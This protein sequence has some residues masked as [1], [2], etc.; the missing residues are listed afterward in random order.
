[1]AITGRADATDA[2]KHA[3]VPRCAP[4]S[5]IPPSGMLPVWKILAIMLCSRGSCVSTHHGLVVES[6]LFT[7]KSTR[8]SVARQESC[9]EFVA[10]KLSRKSLAGSA[11]G[12]GR[13]EPLITPTARRGSQG[14]GGA[15]P[16][17]RTAHAREDT[18]GR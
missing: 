11:V 12:G 17:G 15:A 6:D 13:I 7:L 3:S 18:V 9:N 10:L 4:L 1:M 2:K 14:G 8:F 5:M 16:R